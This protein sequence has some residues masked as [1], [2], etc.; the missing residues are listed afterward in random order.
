MKVCKILLGFAA[1]AVFAANANADLVGLWRFDADANPQP[2]SSEF[3]NNAE[4]FGEAAW[5]NDAERGGV[6]DFPGDGDSNP[7][8]WLEAEDSDSLSIEETGLTIA[9]WAN[10]SQFDTWNSIVSKTGETSQN[11]PS[12]YDMYTNRGGDGRVQFFV[13]EGNG[14]IAP[15]TAEFAPEAEVW[16]HI[17]VTMDEEGEV[18]HYIDGEVSGEGFVDREATFLIDEDQNLFIGSRLDGTTNMH[19]QL[20]DVAIFNEALS[21]DQIST[22]M[23]GDF[24]DFGVGGGLIGD[25]DN[26]GAL[27]VADI[28]MLAA[29]VRDNS[30]D[31][32]FDL[33]S[34]SNIDALDQDVWVN[35]LKN[36]YFG[37]ANLDGEFNSSDFVQVF[38]SGE[39]EDAVVGNSTWATGDWNGD[40][41]FTSS[42]FVKAFQGGGFEQGPRPA[43]VPEPSAIVLLCC[44]ILPLLRRNRK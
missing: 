4:V 8:A 1:L 7:V 32:K 14:A 11:K 43:A 31:G 33:N 19:G 12:P 6:M 18:V 3:G 39:Y 38:Q 22:I 40:G 26:S 2:D 27:D 9:A 44:G 41:D 17:A 23:G 10:F 37:D 42:D 24:S 30:Q 20:D 35:D 13:G 25:F 34:D 36:T 29:A 28:D 15:I 21:E 16:T 5:S